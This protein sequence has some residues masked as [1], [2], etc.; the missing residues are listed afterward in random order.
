MSSVPEEHRQSA[1]TVI[2]CAVVT[3]SDTR[4]LETDTGGQT[5]VDLLTAAGHRVLEREIIPDEPAR[6]LPL[7]EHLRDEAAVDVVLMTGGTG[8]SHRDQTYET[9]SSLLDKP[10]PGY[11]ELF[12]MLSYEEIGAAA[13]LSRAAGG[14]AGR[15]VLLTMPGS[16]AAVHLAMDR[17]ILPEL[18][19]LV[20]EARR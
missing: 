10:L 11:G 19:H 1:P 17:I 3:V 9:V 16:R 8:L 7:L 5:I 6:M 18:T 20:R 13:M 15:T 2:G 4:T 12:R 14:L